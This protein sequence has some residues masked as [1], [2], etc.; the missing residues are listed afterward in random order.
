MDK[1]E[2]KMLWVLA[3][4]QFT[5]IMDFMIMM[6]LGD[7]LME[8][9][10]ISPA[11]FSLIVSAYTLS[12]GIT[13]FASAF[14]IDKYDRKKALLLLYIGFTFGTLC[15]AI[16]P[17]YE[18]LL[19][20]RTVTGAFGGVAGAMILTII[21]DTI[22]LAR[23]S[24]A[25]GFVMAA[26][27]ASSVFGVPFGYYLAE[28]SSWHAPFYL[29]AAM[30]GVITLGLVKFI[31][32][33]RGHLEGKV[34]KN[35]RLRVLTNVIGDRNQLRALLFMV[36]LMLG[37][38]T[39]IPFIAPYME[40][41]VGFEG[42]EI[43]LI[44]LLGGAVTIFTSPRIGKLAD[45]IG[46]HKTYLIFALINLIPILL[47]T[48]LPRSPIGYALAITSLFFV[49]SGGRYIP[50]QTLMTGVVK[51]ENRGSFMNIISSVQQLG[52]SLSSLIAGLIVVESVGGKALV[53]YNYVGYIAVF[54]SLLAVYTSRFIVSK[55]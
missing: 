42:T 44:Y 23:R 1:T 6:P 43:T 2:K 18:L 52:A 4:I 50:A 29:L 10:G 26:F 32:P 47:I 17:S 16:A 8:A 25:M 28:I 5:H 22:P 49:T 55:N 40:R 54:A 11:Q 48:H 38:F 27:S 35:R 13:G 9:F 30:G 19:V 15:C 7:R 12:A 14:F 3:A 53:G 51:A 45:K 33:I 34:E 36:L 39:I 31:P 46:A 20:A 37:Q 41:N 21:G 24:A